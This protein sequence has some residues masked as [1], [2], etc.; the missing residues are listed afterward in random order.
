MVLFFIQVI[1]SFL[2]RVKC[3]RI[4]AFTESVEY[5]KIFPF[6]DIIIKFCLL[7]LINRIDMN[8]SDLI[9]YL[10]Q[11]CKDFKCGKKITRFY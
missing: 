7:I 6:Q 4:I 3:T 8:N 9:N 11:S 10:Q 2:F 5:K 1:K